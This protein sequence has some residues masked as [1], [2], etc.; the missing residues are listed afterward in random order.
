MTLMRAKKSLGQHFLN[1][2]HLA[3]KIVSALDGFEINELIEVGPGKGILTEFL[4]NKPD[5]KTFLVEIDSELILFLRKRFPSLSEQIFECDFLKLDIN[6]YFD[7]PLGIIGNFPYNISSQILFRAI[8]YKNIIK[9]LVGMFQKEVA[10]RI[11]SPPGNKKYGI[12]SVLIQAYFNVE[13]L[14]TVNEDMFIPPP[15][16]KS[17][18]IRLVRNNVKQLDCDERLFKMIV[19]TSFNQRRKIIKNSLKSIVKDLP[20]DFPF[21]DKRPEQLSVESF[22]VL[23]NL[24]EKHL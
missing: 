18:V 15:K 4:I 22:V 8:E 12:L 3:G 11:V 23:T 24:V 14:F 10:E 13:Y 20:P 17:A 16:I 6:K 2:F 19:K 7:K 1:D 5:Y 9:V 21:I